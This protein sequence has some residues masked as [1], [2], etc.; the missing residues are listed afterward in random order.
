MEIVKPKDLERSAVLSM[1]FILL[2]RLWKCIRIYRLCYQCC[3]YS[4]E[5]KDKSGQCVVHTI[6]HNKKLG[7]YVVR[8]C[9][10]CCAITVLTLILLYCTV[11]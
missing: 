6:E 8:L 5:T 2:A 9:V 4:K 3:I 7:T 11:L 10:L 1:K